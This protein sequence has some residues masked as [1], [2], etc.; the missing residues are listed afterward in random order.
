M[1]TPLAEVAG[2][3]KMADLTLLKLAKF[4]SEA[5]GP[6]QSP[7]LISDFLPIAR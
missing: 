4:L 6:L 7:E 3:K 5:A 2:S 1:T